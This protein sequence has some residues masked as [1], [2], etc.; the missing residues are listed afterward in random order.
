M[1]DVFT[2]KFVR[3]SAHDPQEMSKAYSRWSRNSEYFRLLNSSARP[4]QSPKA[5]AKWME[6][7]VG[8][9]SPASYY[10]TIR[11]LDGDKLIGELGLDIV[12]WSGRDAF[13]GLGIGETE[14]WSKGYGT[15]AMNILLR[16]AFSEINLRRMTL[17]VFEYNPRAIRS[18]E[19]AGFQH[20]GRL[21]KILN[22]EG[23]RW[24]MLYMGILR[25]EWLERN[26]DAHRVAVGA[27]E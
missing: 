20:E 17:T 23:K 15:E 16:F 10:F 18:Y 21:R 11:A 24:D 2:G 9:M 1:N 27:G 14:Y 3:L 7:E 5:A 13:V 12:D 8:Q 6:E 26:V 22:K 25:E 4:M 19:K